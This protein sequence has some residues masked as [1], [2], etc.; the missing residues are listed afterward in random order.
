MEMRKPVYICKIRSDLKRDGGMEFIQANTLEKLK[1]DVVKSLIGRNSTGSNSAVVRDT[2]HDTFQ[3]CITMIRRKY[4]VNVEYMVT[5]LPFH[6]R[7]TT[8]S[9]Y[10]EFRKDDMYQTGMYTFILNK[11]GSKC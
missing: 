1:W 6:V 10:R 7:K 9:Y 3:V 2:G 5:E 8:M 4:F 11:E